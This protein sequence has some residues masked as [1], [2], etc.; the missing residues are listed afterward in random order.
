LGGLR[1]V[2]GLRSPR[3]R[4]HPP[5]KS[6]L[7]CGVL[8]YC[9]RAGGFDLPLHARGSKFRANSKTRIVYLNDSLRP[10]RVGGLVRVRMNRPILSHARMVNLGLG[11]KISPA[12]PRVYGQLRASHAP[13][14]RVRARQCAR[15]R[16]RRHWFF[17]PIRVWRL[18][19]RP[20]WSMVG[21]RNSANG[22]INENEDHYPRELEAVCCW[23]MHCIDAAAIHCWRLWHCS[24]VRERFGCREPSG[25]QCWRR[26]RVRTSDPRCESAADPLHTKKSASPHLA[27]LICYDA[28]SGV[29]RCRDS[30]TTSK[31]KKE[32]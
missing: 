8:P 5:F 11:D 21:I 27:W 10:D 3:D 29:R 12:A 4:Q 25:L 9:V 7:G 16:G 20:I 22:R 18:S 1:V 30:E 14:G 15:S 2:R 17:H 32:K 23:R 13:R 24:R 31:R 28:S 26:Q 19:R 6:P